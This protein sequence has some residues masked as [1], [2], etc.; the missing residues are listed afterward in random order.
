MSS[1]FYLNFNLSYDYNQRQNQIRTTLTKHK[2]ALVVGGGPVG[3]EL[4]GELADFQPHLKVTLATGG[5]ALLDR[6]S[7]YGRNEEDSRL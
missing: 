2:H 3:I 5:P 4:A 1:F 7:G 6:V